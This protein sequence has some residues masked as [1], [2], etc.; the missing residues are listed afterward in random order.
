MDAAWR[1]AGPGEATEHPHTHALRRDARTTSTSQGVQGGRAQGLR[2]AAP[3]IQRGRRPAST[4]GAR[5]LPKFGERRRS[6]T[7]S[8]N[9]SGQIE[10]FW[11][12]IRPCEFGTLVAIAI[13]F[14]CRGRWK[15]ASTFSTR[16]KGTRYPPQGATLRAQGFFGSR[17]ARPVHGRWGAT[18][19]SSG[20][21]NGLEFCFSREGL[22]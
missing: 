15:R 10:V 2:L 6:S 12:A 1:G 4:H 11:D 14:G 17:F 13:V 9:P 19:H 8:E 16:G 21:G 22:G 3:I 18:G 5:G 20:R 7:F